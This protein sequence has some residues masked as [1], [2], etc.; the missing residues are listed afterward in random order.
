MN[1]PVS[2]AAGLIELCGLPLAAREALLAGQPDPS[3]DPL[4]AVTR[5]RRERPDLSPGL[6]S[7]VIA[8]RTFRARGRAVG[9]WPGDEAWLATEAGLEQASRPVVAEHRARTLAAAGVVGVVDASAGIGSDA[10]AFLAAGLEVLAFERDSVTAAVCRA[11]LEAAGQEFGTRVRIECAD[12]TD[13]AALADALRNVPSP[14]AIFV[15][16]AR[17][18]TTRPIDGGRSRSERDPRLWSPPWSVVEQWRSQFDLIA[19]KAPPGFRPDSGWKAE[20]IAV[21]DSVVEC[22]LYSPEASRGP[23][24]SATIV[25]ADPPWSLSF[26]IE[27]GPP[28]P[29]GVRGFLAEVH[30]VA[31]RTAAVSKLCEQHPDLAPITEASS[32]LSSNNPGAL[33]PALRWFEVLGTGSIPRLARL[34]RDLDIQRVALKTVEARQSQADIR[35]RIAL[36]DGDEHAIV[37]IR[38]LPGGVL[39]RRMTPT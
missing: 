9:C 7:A 8:Q 38:G 12:S 26:D 2:P 31:R 1:D 28:A 14:T 13:P 11:N 37:V 32:W 18:G 3:H 10:R 22:A 36:P 24:R 6:A 25:D 27:A 34:C 17:R 5:L 21:G 39:V 4:G 20:W 35:A 19:A 29:R 16:P 30:P 23:W 15:D 33:E